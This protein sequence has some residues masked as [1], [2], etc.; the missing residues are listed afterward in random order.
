L[1]FLLNREGAKGA[2]EEVRKKKQEGSSA[3][4]YVTDLTDGKKKE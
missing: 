2:K 3:T 1:I 4:D